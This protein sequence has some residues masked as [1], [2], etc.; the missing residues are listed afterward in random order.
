MKKIHYVYQIIN[1][2]N[3]NIYIGVRS[4]P[5]P[6]ND[7]YMG[8]SKIMNSLYKIEGIENFK[9]EII[10]CFLTR[11][12]AEQYESS[13]QTE[14]FCNDPKTYNIINTG[15]FSENK[16]GFRKDLWY[17][18]FDEIREKYLKGENTVELGQYYSCDQGT[19]RAI[20]QDI[21]RTNS[22]AQ[23]LRFKKDPKSSSNN[24]EWWKKQG[25]SGARNYKIDEKI[26]D[27]LYLYVYEKKSIHF[28]SKFLQ[29]EKGCIIRRLKEN[30]I[31]LRTRNE[32]QKLRGN[33]GRTKSEAWNFKEE[34][35]KQYN[36][37]KN[38]SK[39]AK[40]YKCDVGTIKNILNDGI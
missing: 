11:E 24:K 16:H 37:E 34:I 17:E 10:K 1:L 26:D 22:E 6:E 8:S 35:I 30:N 2:K 32:S 27:I 14:E 38:M 21:K 39:I 3:N 15:K 33:S 20:I 18:Y 13:L 19:I 9:K 4:S 23:K 12:E 36:K 28:I 5:D 31:I 25:S 7:L 29:I 40:E